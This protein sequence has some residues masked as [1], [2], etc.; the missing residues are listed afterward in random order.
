MQKILKSL[1]ELPITVIHCAYSNKCV[2]LKTR[3]ENVAKS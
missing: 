2:R 1:L 3:R